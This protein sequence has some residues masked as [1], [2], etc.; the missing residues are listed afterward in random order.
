MIALDIQI[1][2]VAK[3]CQYKEIIEKKSLSQCIWDDKRKEHL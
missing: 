1:G 3:Q 2:Q